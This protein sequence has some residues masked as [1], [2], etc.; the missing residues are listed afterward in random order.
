V[1]LVDSLSPSDLI[2][3]MPSEMDL[4]VWT[5]VPKEH[6]KSINKESK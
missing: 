1:K 3:L 6:I 2:D 5:S 4:L